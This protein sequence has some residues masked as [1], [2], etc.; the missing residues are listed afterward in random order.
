MFSSLCKMCR[1]GHRDCCLLCKRDVVSLQGKSCAEEL[2]SL[3][4]HVSHSLHALLSQRLLNQSKYV[5]YILDGL[6]C[7]TKC[8]CLIIVESYHCLHMFH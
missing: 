1:L 6:C 7:I 4:R 3:H 2:F 5:L 8:S